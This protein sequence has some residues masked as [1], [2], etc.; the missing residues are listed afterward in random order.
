[1]AE[2]ELKKLSDPITKQTLTS[3][4]SEDHQIPEIGTTVFRDISELRDTVKT[5]CAQGRS[6][7]RVMDRLLMESLYNNLGKLPLKVSTDMK[8]WHWICTKVIKDYIWVRWGPGEVP[9]DPREY[10]SGV[11]SDDNQPSLKSL[12]TRF[13]G[14][15]SLEGLSRNSAARLYFCMDRL[16]LNGDPSL[17]VDVLLNSELQLQSF[18]TNIF[19]HP[20]ALRA[21]V[22]KWKSLKG[23]KVRKLSTRTR[24]FF[25]SRAAE[26]MSEDEISAMLDNLSV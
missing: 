9:S 11:D 7:H 18:E 3:T 1:M 19:L 14:R 20:P 21:C 15:Y 24:Q 23:D 10:L 6:N 8:F 22:N 2:E 25:T 12:F 4:L 17:A 16:T 5:V 13:A 26:T